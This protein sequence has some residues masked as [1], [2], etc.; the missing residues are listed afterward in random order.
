MEESYCW[1]PCSEQ[2]CPG[3]S[4]VSGSIRVPGYSALPVESKAPVSFQESDYLASSPVWDSLASFPALSLT[5]LPCQA[6]APLFPAWVQR[7]PESA[8]RYP[9]EVESLVVTCS[10]S[11]MAQAPSFA[12]QVLA[13]MP[14][15]G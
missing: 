2:S 3:L 13:R 8:Q 1:E 6:L 4:A 14:P 9:T 11:A 7:F 12:P 15:S 5:A 10:A